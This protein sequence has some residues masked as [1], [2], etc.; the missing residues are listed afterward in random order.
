MKDLNGKKTSEIW[1]KWRGDHKKC[2]RLYPPR[3]G[4]VKSAGR[5]REDGSSQIKGFLGGEG[6]DVGASS[7]TQGRKENI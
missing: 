7:N 4:T 2:R 6:I 1:R 5:G 3:K